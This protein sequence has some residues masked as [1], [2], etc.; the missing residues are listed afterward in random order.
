MAG[1]QT[2]LAFR[3][4][5]SYTPPMYNLRQDAADGMEVLAAIRPEEFEILA[6]GQPAYP[7]WCRAACS[8][9]HPP[10]TS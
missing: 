10:T 8:W 5:P 4:E 2:C 6:Q 3:D 9:A 7:P 1:G